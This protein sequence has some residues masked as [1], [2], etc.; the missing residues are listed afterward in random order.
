MQFSE[1]ELTDLT[2]AV[3]AIN[4]WNRIAISCRPMPG[5]TIR[6]RSRN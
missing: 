6:S 5:T 1:K 3:V 2:R 4:C